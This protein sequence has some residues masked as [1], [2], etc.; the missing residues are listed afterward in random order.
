[1]SELITFQSYISPEEAQEVSG[2]LSENGIK[3]E[4]GSNSP[5]VDLTL[6]GGG[7]SNQRIEIKIQQEDFDAANKILELE[8][9]KALSEVSK[10]HYLFEFTNEELFDVLLKK[11]EWSAFDFELSKKILDERGEKVSESLL[12]QLRIQRL[13]DLAKPEQGQKTWIVVGYLLSLLGGF[14]GLAIGWYIWKSKK[15]LPNGD[16]VFASSEKDRSHGKNIFLI[17]IIGMIFWLYLSWNENSF[18]YH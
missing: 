10:D 5:S 8:A 18:M 7:M 16:R 13:N 15:T 4:L 9:D 12:N 1:M 11:E 2:I 14:F 17:G 6:T 3:N